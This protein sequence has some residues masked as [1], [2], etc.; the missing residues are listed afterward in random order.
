MQFLWIMLNYFHYFSYEN[1]KIL[2][3]RVSDFLDFS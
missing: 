1:W 2:F 3:L